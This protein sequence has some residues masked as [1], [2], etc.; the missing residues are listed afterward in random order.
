MKASLKIQETALAQQQQSQ[1]DAHNPNPD[2]SS[3]IPLTKNIHSLKTDSITDTTS[4][5]CPQT[6]TPNLDMPHEPVNMDPEEVINWIGTEY[7]LNS[8]QWIGFCIIARSFIEAHLQMS[9][10]SEPI[11]ILLTGPGGTGKTHVVN[12]LCALMAVYGS[13]HTLR[14]L[15]PTGSAASLIDGMTI[16]KGLGIKIKSN[17][18]GKGNREVGESTEDYTVLISIRNRTLLRDEWRLVKVLFID[19]VSLLSEQLMSEIDHALRYATERPNE[20]FG[21]ISVVFAGD[22]FQYSPIAATPLPLA[23]SGH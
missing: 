14:F 21:R 15:A 12:A 22:F 3:S 20:W 19:E 1:T 18:K 4:P 10:K 8:Q 7:Q 5:A 23:R 17:K 11:R 6:D 2:F 16:H 9:A 13:E